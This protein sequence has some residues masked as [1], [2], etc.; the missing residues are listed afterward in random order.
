LFIK[1]WNNVSEC[2][3]TQENSNQ[4]PSTLKLPPLI[5]QVFLSWSSLQNLHRN[6]YI[7]VFNCQNHA[8]FCQIVTRLVRTTQDATNLILKTC[9]G[10]RKSSRFPKI[11]SQLDTLQNV[12][13]AYQNR[14]TL[15]KSCHDS[16][17]SQTHFS[18]TLQHFSIL[19][20]KWWWCH[21]NHQPSFSFSFPCIQLYQVAPQVYTRPSS[22]T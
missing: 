16:V 4:R 3:P 6:T 21:F 10:S 2:F 1:L 9:P 22:T 13:T 12:L 14:D 20:L 7:A 11:V 5:S 8:T 18:V 19:T 15:A 17:F